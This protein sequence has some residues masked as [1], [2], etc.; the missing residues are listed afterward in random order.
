GY[1]T[2]DIKK[3]H[4]TITI[5]HYFSYLAHHR[6]SLPVK[7]ILEMFHNHLENERLTTSSYSLDI[8]PSIIFFIKQQLIDCITLK[9][10]HIL[11]GKCL[12]KCSLFLINNNQENLDNDQYEQIPLWIIDDLIMFYLID[13]EQSIVECTRYT[14]KI[15]LN[16]SSGQELYQKNIKNNLIEIYSKP[17]LSQINF[18]LKIQTNLNSLTNPWLITSFDTWFIS[19]INYLLKQIE[20]YYIEKKEIGHPCAFIFIQLKQLI[21][22]KID[23]GKKLFP[24]LIYCLLL[25]PINLNIR[26]LLTENFTFLLEQLLNNKFENNFTYIQIAKI[27]FRTINFLR[28][29]PIENLNKRNAGKNLFL[30]FEN[31]FWLDIDYFQLAKCASKYQCYQSAIIYTDIWTTKQRTL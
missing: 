7:W 5:S 3:K 23:L 22:L 14:L 25:L 12:S 28:Q 21:Q 20:Y 29:C 1:L 17:F 27:F 31:H 11:A 19:L 6:S 8:D 16:H 2:N 24:H 30:N 4:Q 13:K 15:I 9:Q 18:P 26:Q 10:N